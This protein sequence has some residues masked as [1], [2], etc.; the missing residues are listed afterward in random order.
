MTAVVAVWSVNY[1]V[2]G[3]ARFESLDVSREPGT[4]Y[5][6]RVHS[7]T[8]CNTQTWLADAGQ[9][10][11]TPRKNIVRATFRE[12]AGMEQFKEDDDM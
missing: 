1:S 4:L 8:S 10:K 7:S 6:P 2:S 9:T 12:T 3:G 11:Y 5:N